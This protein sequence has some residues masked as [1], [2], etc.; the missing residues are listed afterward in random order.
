LHS[1]HP[2]TGQEGSVRPRFRTV[3]ALEQFDVDPSE[4]S[5]GGKFGLPVLALVLDAALGVYPLAFDLMLLRRL[6]ATARESAPE[7]F[8]H[9]PSV[10]SGRQTKAGADGYFAGADPFR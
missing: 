6:G 3:V 1:P 7:A 5:L 8:Q 2:R 10:T 4:P 9:V